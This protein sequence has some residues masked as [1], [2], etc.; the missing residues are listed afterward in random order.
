[1]LKAICHDAAKAFEVLDQLKSLSNQLK[2]KKNPETDSDT[3]KICCSQL[4]DKWN[5]ISEKSNVN[6]IKKRLNKRKKFK[7]SSKKSF[8]QNELSNLF[9]K[10]QPLC[11]NGENLNTKLNPT[12]EKVIQS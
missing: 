4:N 3:I 11:S 1:M 10:M 8:Y 5:N 2:E 7:R 9:K 6:I 12:S